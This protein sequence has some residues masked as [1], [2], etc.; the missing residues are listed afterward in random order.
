MIGVL[1]KSKETWGMMAIWDGDWG[2]AVKNQGMCEAI[3]AG[4][5]KGGFSPIGFRGSMALPTLGFILLQ[6]LRENTFLLFQPILVCDT[7]LWHLRKL[8]QCLII[9]YV[10]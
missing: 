8:I 4:R 5:G 7:S 10:F 1:I 6:K 2:D 3:D 9:M